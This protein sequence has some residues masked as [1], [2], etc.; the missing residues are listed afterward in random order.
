MAL[1]KRTITDKIETCRLKDHFIISVRE[2]HQV[3]ED[4]KLLSQNFSRYTLS[5]DYDLS[6]ITDTTVKSQFEAVMTD[7][8]KEN[9]QAFLKAKN[10]K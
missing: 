4:G 9:Y 2:A 5:P 8:I 10:E 6:K 1:K 7:K 3:L